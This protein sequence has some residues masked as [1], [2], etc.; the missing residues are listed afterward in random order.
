MYVATATAFALVGDRER[1]KAAVKA[2]RQSLNAPPQHAAPSDSSVSMFLK[3][4]NG[5][6]E[7]ECR[8]ILDYLNSSRTST[9]LHTAQA[10]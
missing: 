9:T 4:R 3:L 10:N 8:R 1:A 2:A 7:R 5:E 6:V